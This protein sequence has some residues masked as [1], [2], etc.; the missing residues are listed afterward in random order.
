MEE[1]IDVAALLREHPE[2]AHFP[3]A[4]FMRKGPK[5]YVG[6]ALT[7]A[8]TLYFNDA[9]TSEVRQAICECFEEYEATA[10]DHLT[11]L[12]RA[13]PSEGPDKIAYKNAKSMRDIMKRM[14]END[15]VSF[16][17]ISGANP[18][19]AGDWEFVVDGW[20]GWQAKMG[21]WG[22]CSLRF[23]LPLL[24]VHDNPQALQAMFVSFA[25][26]LKA[27][28]GYAGP[29]LNLSVVRS[30]ENEPFEA[31]ISDQTKALD[32]G[33]ELWTNR[34]VTAGIKT[35]SWLTAINYEM[36]K[37]IGGLSTIRSE[38]PRDWFALY[39]YGAGLVIQAGPK[40]NPAAV[41]TDP[42]PAIYVLPNMLLKE[43]RTPDIGSLHNGSKDGEPRIIGHAAEQWLKRFDIPE[44]ELLAYKAKLL[45]EPKLTKDT[46]LPERL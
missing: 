41:K 20:R 32:V 31:Y 9:H 38:L 12:W 28:H 18:E 21:T 2:K 37:K 7:M 15:V 40:A 19:D 24:Y 42:K 16:G 11:W 39:D 27:V 45:E 29:A 3:G 30:D 36:V 6:S 33:H 23:S 4:L 25:K 5:D 10:R 34:K 43:V 22:L 46:T 14:G 8:G 44:E 17:Y 35:V 1:D 26:R 13:E